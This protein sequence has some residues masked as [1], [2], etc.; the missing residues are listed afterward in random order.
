[1]R[2]DTNISRQVSR[3]IS[4]KILKLN[5]AI[6]DESARIPAVRLLLRLKR[7]T[8]V[9]ETYYPEL[10]SEDDLVELLPDWR[11][12]ERFESRVLPPA[13]QPKTSPRVIREHVRLLRVEWGFPIVSFTR[14]RGEEPDTAVDDPKRTWGYRWCTGRTDW[15]R[16][17]RR[18][19]PEIRENIIAQIQRYMAVDDFEEEL[20]G[21]RD[22][23][24]NDV[25]AAAK[26]LCTA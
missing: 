9:L 10:V 16:Y 6:E 2:T 3:N 7:L 24:F 13:K 25:L 20:W 21:T 12:H 14:K 8:N 11:C 23:Y 26:G 4:A 22:D 18:I 19:R 5:A 1:M 15:G 17:K